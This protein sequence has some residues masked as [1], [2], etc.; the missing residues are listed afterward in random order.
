MKFIKR[1]IKLFQK[2]YSNKEQLLFD[3]DLCVCLE[4]NLS[5]KFDKNLL[6]IF[7]NI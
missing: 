2:I 1:I 4:Q 7:T 3:E 6:L 5:E